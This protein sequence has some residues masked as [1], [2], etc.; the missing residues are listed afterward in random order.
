MTCCSL[1][2]SLCT[3]AYMC[4]CASFRFVLHG[5]AN[6]DMPI[7]C[8]IFLK[9]RMSMSV[10]EGRGT[11]SRVTLTCAGDACRLVIVRKRRS[12]VYVLLWQQYTFSAVWDVHWQSVTLH[13]FL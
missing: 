9:H 8:L 10:R 1:S 11:L 4:L 7:G 13:W 3:S 5:S 12:S 6:K 2:L